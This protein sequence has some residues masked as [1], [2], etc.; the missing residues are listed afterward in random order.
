MRAFMTAAPAAFRTATGW[1]SR[2]CVRAATV[3]A[4]LVC[5]GLVLTPAMLTAQAALS[6]RVMVSA[7]QRPLADAS[8]TLPTLGLL[9][10][11]DSLGRYHF[12]AVPSGSHPIVVRAPGYQPDSGVVT[13]G[14]QPT[15]YRNVALRRIA[16]LEE[17]RVAGGRPIP[18]QMRGFEERRARGEGHFVTRDDLAKDAH[19]QTGEIIAKLAPG[20]R[21]RRGSSRAWA[22][23]G[24]TTSGAT[25]AMCKEQQVLDPADKAMGAKPACY[26]DV[27]L[28]G[29]LVYNSAQRGGAPLWDLNSMR[30]DQIE[31][32]EVYT[33]AAQTPPQFNRTSGGCGVVLIWTRISP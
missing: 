4:T 29:A 8:V 24:R 18:A 26:M 6:G 13:L 16:T 23:N 32:V 33:G 19:R 12:A 31:G 28:D 10:R 5:G 7:D 14:D 22:T 17:V 9:T 25:C 11:T 2:R 3:G 27:Y 15:V 20:V 1:W 21:L 30:P